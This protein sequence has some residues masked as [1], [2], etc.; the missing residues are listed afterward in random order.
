MT[1]HQLIE[2]LTPIVIVLFIGSCTDSY[3]ISKLAKAL[4]KLEAKVND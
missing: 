1:D 4:R 3:R 2:I